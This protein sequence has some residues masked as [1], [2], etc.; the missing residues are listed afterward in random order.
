MISKEGRFWNWAFVQVGLYKY[1]VSDAEYDFQ[2]FLK[3]KDFWETF[4]IFK[5]KFQNNFL[6]SSLDQV[7]WFFCVDILDNNGYKVQLE[8]SL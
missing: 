1:Y 5:E 8:Q 4:K 3:P 7:L 2:N 6:K